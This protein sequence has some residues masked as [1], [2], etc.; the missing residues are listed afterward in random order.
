MGFSA[1]SRTSHYRAV[2]LFSLLSC[3]G[4]PSALAALPNMPNPGLGA[5]PPP[6]TVQIQR[7]A[8]SATVQ[9]ATDGFFV[10]TASA[11]VVQVEVTSET[12]Q[13]VSG[14]L[15][16]LTTT[17]T[18][19]TVL[20]WSANEPLVIGVKYTAEVLIPSAPPPSPPGASD[21]V[22]LEVMGPPTELSESTLTFG[23]WV[24]F[25]HGV[26][27]PTTCKS[28]YDATYVFNLSSAEEKRLGARMEWTPPSPIVGQVA[29]TAHVELPV[30]S[31]ALTSL[32][33]HAVYMG[34][35]GSIALGTLVFPADASELCAVLVVR[36]IRRTTEL[37][38]QVCGEPGKTAA[39]ERDYPLA[40][41]AGPPSAELYD[42]WCEL[43]ASDPQC[44]VPYDP[45]TAH[46][47]TLQPTPPSPGGAAGSTA[48]GSAGSAAGGSAGS[49]GAS[50]LSA[51]P[52]YSDDSG[53]Q[54]SPSS[55]R[56]GVW[57]LLATA[58]LLARRRRS[59]PA[60]A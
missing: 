36:D 24:D 48:S 21:Q 14:T 9:V 37:R 44:A 16:N 35:P 54:L 28:R 10:M 18:I 11:P 43:Y 30:R 19:D 56:G 59:A 6:A 25:R 45:N 2:A 49:A 23:A 39:I 27:A 17:N 58:A 1:R 46:P 42:A 15:Q 38:Q 20:G 32:L 22:E 13:L 57:A 4:V 31:P 33:P 29:W 50:S 52:R 60:Q 47:P 8:S 26:G 40:S 53:C 3:V 5:P 55:G 51:S 7:D 41:C 34:Q 12:G